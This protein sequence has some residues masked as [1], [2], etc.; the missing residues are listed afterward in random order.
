MNS[1]FDS[2]NSIVPFFSGGLI[3]LFLMKNLIV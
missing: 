3:S 1:E 2:F